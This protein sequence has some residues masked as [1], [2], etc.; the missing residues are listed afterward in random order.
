MNAKLDKKVDVEIYSELIPHGTS[1]QQ[2]LRELIEKNSLELS[3]S[4]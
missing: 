3:K 2:H 1:A 4:Y